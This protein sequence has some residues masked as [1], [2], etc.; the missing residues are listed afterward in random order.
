MK[1]LTVIEVV[2]D[3]FIVAGFGDTFEE[4]VRDYNKKRIAFLQRCSERGVKL[5]VEKLK[6]CLEEVPLIGHY[7]AK[8][9][10]KI[11]P[12]KEGVSF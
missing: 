6:L 5:S 4:A 7:A 12:E 9:G 10:L 11:H 1:V 3:A 2:A 8:S